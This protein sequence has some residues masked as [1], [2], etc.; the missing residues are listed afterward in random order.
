MSKDAGGSGEV[1]AD[2]G[3]HEAGEEG[4]AGE[5]DEVGFGV[6][7]GADVGFEE[8]HEGAD[9]VEEEDDLGFAEGFQAEGEEEDLQGEGGEEEGVVPGEGDVRG[10]EVLAEEDEGEEDAAEE[11]GPGLLEAEDKELPEEGV[12]ATGGDVA[13]Q[14][15]TEGV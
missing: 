1:T 7:P 11:A 12:E 9:D 5:A 15:E 2:G 13:F 8:L 3:V 10:P 14:T 4:D 6:R